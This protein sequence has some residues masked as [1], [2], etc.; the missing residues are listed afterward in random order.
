MY[1]YDVR[2]MMV[3]KAFLSSRFILGDVNR[4]AIRIYNDERSVTGSESPESL[5]LRQCV[6]FDRGI[7]A[8]QD[9]L[10]VDSESQ[11]TLPSHVCSQKN[12][13]FSVHLIVFGLYRYGVLNL[14]AKQIMNALSNALV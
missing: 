3:A 4:R 10:R 11:M 14:T 13:I 9:L 2:K 8:D 5:R 7:L 12:D 1:I 6:W